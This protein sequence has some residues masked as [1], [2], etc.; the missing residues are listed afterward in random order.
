[1]ASH[2]TNNSTTIWVALLT[3][4]DD[5]VMDLTDADAS[6]REHAEQMR[7]AGILTCTEPNCYTLS[8]NGSRLLL[9]LERLR[10][11]SLGIN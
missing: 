2:P 1:M 11:Y 9:L 4:C 8:S 10:D 3:S 7:D 6:A 5:R